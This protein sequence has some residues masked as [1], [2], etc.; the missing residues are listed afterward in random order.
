MTSI[1]SVTLE[2]ADP[3]AVNRFSAAV[4]LG[5]RVRHLASE[6]R[7]VVEEQHRSGNS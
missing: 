2:V 5:T 1:E 7:D 6:G 4:G 3:A